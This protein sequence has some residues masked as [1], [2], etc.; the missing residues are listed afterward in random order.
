MTLSTEIKVLSSL[1]TREAHLELVP[2]FER[3]TGHKVTTTWA[4][5]VDIVKRISAGEHFDLIVASS[6]AIDDLIRNG[7]IE[8]GSRVDI[9]RSGIGVAV[10]RG[11]PRPEI[12]SAEALKRALMAARTV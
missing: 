3:A 6:S 12:G 10:R 9:A 5:T 2:Q 4:G 1:A 7:K 8:N 11:T